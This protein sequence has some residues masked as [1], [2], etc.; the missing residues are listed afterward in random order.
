MKAALLLCTLLILGSHT[1]H[2]QTSPAPSLSA[3]FYK[4]LAEAH[5]WLQRKHNDKSRAILQVLAEQASNSPYENGMVWNM[6]GYLHYQNGDLKQSA[7][8]Y[9]K[10]LGFDIPAALAQDTRKILGQVYLGDGHYQQAA[11][12]FSVWLNQASTDTEAVHGWIA[13]CY[14][15]MGQFRKAAQHLNTAIGLYQ[16]AQRQ[17]KEEWLALLQAS[18]AQLDEA[19][20][21]IATL[22]RLLAWYPKAEYWLALAN[23]YGQA[24]NLPDYLATLAVAQRKDLLRTESQYLSLASLFHSREV[25]LQAAHMIEQGLRRN[26]V[27]ANAKNLRFLASCYTLAQEFDKALA[28]LQQAASLSPDGETD[29]LLGNAYFQLGRWQEAADA[30][31]TAITKG[32]LK[33]LNTVWL[34]LGQTWLNLHRFDQ[35]LHAFNQ[36][37]LDE[38]RGHRAE[39]WIKYAEYEQQRYQELGLIKSRLPAPASKEKSS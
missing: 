33:Q 24:D 11:R 31:A 6:L 26:I 27:T 10:S 21:R 8:A 18:L 29:A 39:Q 13:Q 35:A 38:T 9:E 15:Q 34:L 32:E 25:P 17:P 16:Q 1:A 14:Y 7:D 12:H 4:K 5:D 36:A 22:K 28:P 19:K 37:S 2:A 3:G 30:L 23:A 20:D